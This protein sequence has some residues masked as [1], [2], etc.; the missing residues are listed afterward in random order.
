MQRGN[1]P[2]TGSQR[3]R[4]KAAQREQKEKSLGIG[5]NTGE[6]Q[7]APTSAKQPQMC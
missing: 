1:A 2:V 3:K 6:I 4:S 5:M 7:C